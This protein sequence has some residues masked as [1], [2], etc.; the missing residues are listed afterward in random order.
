MST[1]QRVL[2]LTVEAS[3]DL[4]ADQ[5]KIVDI[6]S[7]GQIALA[8]AGGGIG[9]LQDAPSAAGAAGSVGCGGISK[10]LCGG[11]VT[12]GGPVASNASG[13]AIDALTTNYIIGQALDTGASGDIIR[14]LMASP[15]RLA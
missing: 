12:K 6:D 3:A 5:Y 1:E 9:I 14:V 4:S 7:N 8:G 11:T 15:G 10:V 13:L 2:T